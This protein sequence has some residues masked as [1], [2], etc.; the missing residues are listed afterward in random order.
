M[1]SGKPVIHVAEY[2]SFQTAKAAL[3]YEKGETL[4][5]WPKTYTFDWINDDLIQNHM[6]V[7]D[8]RIELPSGV[9]YGVLYV[10]PRPDG[11]MPLATAERLV[12]MVEEGATLVLA[13]EPPKRC[14]GLAGYPESDETLGKV[15][16]ETLVR[17]ADDQ[18]GERRP[19]RPHPHCGEESRRDR[20]GVWKTASHSASST[21]KQP[22]PISSSS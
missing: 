17:S 10:A 7:R 4:S 12:E 21:E 11:S 6:K 18:T 22:I 1:Q 3:W 16:R 8:G 20:S 14:P 5:E 2:R 9:A 15:G 19:L 13:G